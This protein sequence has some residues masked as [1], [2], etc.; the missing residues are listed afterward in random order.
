MTPSYLAPP[1]IATLPQAV[2]QAAMPAEPPSL[3]KGI[4]TPE[5]IAAQKAQY[6]AALDK[7]LETAKNTV[8]QETKIEQQMA[9]FNADKQIDLYRCQ[10]EEKRVE[11]EALVE[12]QATIQ[13]LELKKA[14]VER[15]L[16]LDSQAANLTMDYKMKELMT[17]CAMKQYQF[18]QQYVNAENKLAAQ[19]NQQYVNAENKL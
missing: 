10:V 3:T 13:S 11:Q 8:I 14:L 1:Q 16:Q 6:A 9:K 5:Q 18:Q 7:Q 2:P 19:Y 12:E 15:N 4:P 17:S